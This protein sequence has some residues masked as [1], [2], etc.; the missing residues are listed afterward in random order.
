M[1]RFTF[2]THFYPGKTMSDSELEE[3]VSQIREVAS[4][5]FDE[6]PDY[7]SLTGKREELSRAVITLAHDKRGKLMGF[8]SALVLPVYEVG[9]VLH[10]GLT[11]V[12]PE[13]RGRKLTHKLTS[14]ML[15]NYLFKESPFS[16]T[17]ITNCACVLSSLGNVALYFEELYPSPYGEEVP[18]MTHLNIGR[19]VSK[20][21]RVPIAIND[22]AVFNEKKFIFEASV[23]G[24]IFTKD[25]NDTRFHHRDETITN[26][27]KDI[28]DFERGDE[29]L[30]VG[31]VSLLTFPKYMAK[32]AW[33]KT[34][35]K[36]GLQLAEA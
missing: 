23:P 5:C 6:C 18:S 31:K 29:V 11:C 21:Y 20:K 19:E 36:F 32:R 30:Q 4:L 13:A 14:K 35:K 15:L 8:V 34:K 26:F 28:L 3:L 22:D 12:H 7:Q 10:L 1:P 2:K 25:P 33:V 24:T 9:D 17:W 27:Y 16:E